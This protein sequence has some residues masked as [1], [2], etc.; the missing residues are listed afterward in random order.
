MLVFAAI[1]VFKSSSHT[2]KFESR[3]LVTIKPVKKHFF[4]QT[5]QLKAN[6]GSLQKMLDSK[7]SDFGHAEAA[8]KRRVDALGVSVDAL[9]LA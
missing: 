6:N 3:W 5:A 4:G 8:L 7:E 1:A 9:I 2:R